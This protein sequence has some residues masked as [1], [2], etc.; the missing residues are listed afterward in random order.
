MIAE[1]LRNDFGDNI[2]NTF[3][4]IVEDPAY[5]SEQIGEVIGKSVRAV[6]TDISNSRMKKWLKELELGDIQS[7]RE[8]FICFQK[9]LYD[10]KIA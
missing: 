2:F 6:K 8:N 3:N 10:E 1:W 7:I 5:K 9:N 4:V